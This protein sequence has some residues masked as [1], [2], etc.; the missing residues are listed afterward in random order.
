MTNQEHGWV[1][2]K[3]FS[4]QASFLCLVLALGTIG[5]AAKIGPILLLYYAYKMALVVLLLALLQY[6][7]AARVGYRQGLGKITAST[8]N[9][10]KVT[11]ILFIIKVLVTIGML[12]CLIM[13]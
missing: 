13:I 3:Y 1:E 6:T 8:L 5:L 4:T 11:K 12:S 7:S 2:Y 10:Y 9:P